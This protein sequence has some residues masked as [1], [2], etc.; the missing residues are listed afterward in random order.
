MLFY[1]KIY[2]GSRLYNLLVFSDASIY[3]SWCKGLL[4]D[5][6][7]RSDKP[8]TT[9]C[10]M[11]PWELSSV[12]FSLNTFFIEENI[13]QNAFCK[14]VP[15]LSSANMLSEEQTETHNLN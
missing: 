7:K 6:S 12:I 10:Q 1:Q 8:V 9:F 3:V 5:S 11:D 4:S 2:S 15:I 13:F 14:M